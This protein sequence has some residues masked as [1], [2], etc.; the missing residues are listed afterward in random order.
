MTVGMF[1]SIL[2]PV[3]AMSGP[4]SAQEVDP[5]R[6]A[7][8]K[9]GEIKA[10]VGQITATENGSAATPDD[11]AKRADGKRFVYLGENHATKEHQQLE[12]DVVTA[13]QKRGRK[14][15]VGLEMLTRPTQPALDRFI[16]GTTDEATFLT[17]SDWK[18]QWGYDYGFYRPL[19]EAARS[20]KSTVVALNV[21]RDWVRS[22]GRGG[23][24]A[25]TPQQ[26]SQLPPVIEVGAGR[27]R[28]VFDALMGGHPP[29]GADRMLAAQTLWDEG[30]ADTAI[31]ALGSSIDDPNVVMVIVAGSGH[32]MYGQGINLRIARRTGRRG[33]NVVM[34]QA[35]ET[36]PVS[37]GVA[38]FVF[39]SR[40][41]PKETK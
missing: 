37:K 13:L 16:D 32:V 14:V 23:L 17:E 39:I 8:G 3:F 36:T 15:I 25:L 5:M 9:A 2:L 22:V 28:D 40:P 12:A 21:P 26:R 41:A 31:E 34:G 11:I 7:I 29:S 10:P 6:L 18:K 27:H 19:L 33:V 30:M 24:D 38:D 4:K 35:T 20:K 1:L